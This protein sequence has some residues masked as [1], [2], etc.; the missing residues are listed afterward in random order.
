MVH[1]G[2]LLVLL[3]F[4]FEEPLQLCCTFFRQHAAL[5]HGLVVQRGLLKQIDNRARRAS[6]RV[7][8]AEHNAFEP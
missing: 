6:F 5:Q 2:L 4:G 7:R 3:A 1:F 8:R